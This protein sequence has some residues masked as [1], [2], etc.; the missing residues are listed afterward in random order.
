[1][2]ILETIILLSCAIIMSVFAMGVLY[3]AA[4][5]VI[6]GLRDIVDRHRH[7]KRY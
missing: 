5:V 4:N 3:F 7:D 6:D 1:M 2:K